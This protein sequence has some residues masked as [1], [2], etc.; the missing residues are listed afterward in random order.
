ML[1]GPSGSVVVRSTSR[2]PRAEK[3]ERLEEEIRI[4]LKSIDS[5]LDIKYIEWAGRYSLICQWPQSDP[6]WEMF[7][8]GETDNHH[9]NLGWFCQDMQDPTSLPVDIDSIENLVLARLA[10]CDNTKHSWRIRMQEIIAKNAKLRT[11]RK[12][13]VLDRVGDIAGTLFTAAGH[14]DTHQLER[15]LEEVEKG[16]H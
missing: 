15:L 8:R 4:K 9:D 11:S 14:M 13:Q 12:E 5:L 10:S 3:N 2:T 1:Y 6:R 16:K 7:Q